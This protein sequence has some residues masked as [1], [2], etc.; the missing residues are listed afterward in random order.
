VALTLIITQKKYGLLYHKNIINMK[1][2][3]NS[4]AIISFTILGITACNKKDVNLIDENNKWVLLDSTNSAN[5]KIVHVFAGNTPQIPTAPNL[6]TGPQVLIYANGLK[7]NGTSISYGGVFPTPNVYANV[8]EGNNKIEII[9]GRL[10]LTVVPNVPNFI[11]GDT[12]ATVNSVLQ[13]GKYYTLYITDTVPTVRTVIKED[14]LPL[15]DYQM[16]KIRLANMMM[17]PLDTLTLFSRRQNAEI[18]FDITHKNVSDWIQLPLPIIPDTFELRKKGTT[19]TY[20]T[21]NFGTT[22]TI[23]PVGQ[24]MYTVVARGK[25]GVT[26]KLPSAFIFTNR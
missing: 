23:T 25:T 9:N 4:L 15:P 8:P 11:A 19:T 20:V 6:T 24:R 16:Y 18:I 7:L 21:A 13:K 3:L 26:A 5:L 17:N 22:P 14:L 10:N 2:I 12:L 1:L